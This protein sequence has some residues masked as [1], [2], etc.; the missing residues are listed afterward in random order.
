MQ[1]RK[2]LLHK[3]D[4]VRSYAGAVYPLVADGITGGPDPADLGLRITNRKA[5]HKCKARKTLPLEE[6][7]QNL[8]VLAT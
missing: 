5:V 7:I 8:V 1:K 4:L 3:I 2:P 6:V